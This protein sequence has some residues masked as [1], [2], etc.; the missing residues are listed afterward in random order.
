L[1]R[2]GARKLPPA[3]K[4]T[5]EAAQIEPITAEGDFYPDW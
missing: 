3:N 4:M 5:E 2:S 1:E